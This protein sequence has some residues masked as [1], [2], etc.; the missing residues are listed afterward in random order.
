MSAILRKPSTTKSNYDT[1]VN[2]KS[3]LEGQ[4]QLIKSVIILIIIF[5]QAKTMFTSININYRVDRAFW[6]A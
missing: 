6:G 1:N 2:I 5:K 4:Q 3:F